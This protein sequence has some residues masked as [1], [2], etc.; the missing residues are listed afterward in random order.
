M[1]KLMYSGIGT[2]SAYVFYLIFDKNQII[3][4]DKIV[5]LIEVIAFFAT[6][7][8]HV[9]GLF[10]LVAAEDAKKS[11]KSLI[12]LAKKYIVFGLFLHF[13]FVCGYCRITF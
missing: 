1:R 7:C 3:K 11:F 8:V 13:F 12:P 10:V 5:T 2:I 4:A 9:Y 6:F